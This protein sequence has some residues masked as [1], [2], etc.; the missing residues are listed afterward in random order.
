MPGTFCKPE[1]EQNKA[2]FLARH[3]YYVKPYLVGSIVTINYGDALSW[4]RSVLSTGSRI[5]TRLRI[6]VVSLSLP[7]VFTEALEPYLIDRHLILDLRTDPQS[8]PRPGL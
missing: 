2:L 1:A 7:Y 6:V 4:I 5:R 3:N 8:T